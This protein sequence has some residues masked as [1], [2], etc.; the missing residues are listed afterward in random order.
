MEFEI[1][2]T[3]MKKQRARE[4]GGRKS[5]QG[6]HKTNKPLLRLASLHK[7]KIAQQRNRYIINKAQNLPMISQIWG[8]FYITIFLTTNLLHFCELCHHEKSQIYQ[9]LKHILGNCL[10]LT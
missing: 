6:L 4:V 7:I 8:F 1:E 9:V 10:E 2:E 3:R 5:L